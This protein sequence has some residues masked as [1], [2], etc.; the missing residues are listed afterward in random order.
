MYIH[1]C[2]V[3]LVQLPLVSESSRRWSNF[4]EYETRFS[5]QNT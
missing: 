5:L 3:L 2:M 1:P 4:V